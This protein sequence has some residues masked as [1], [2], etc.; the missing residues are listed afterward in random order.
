[1]SR[2]LPILDIIIVNWNAGFLL[3]ACL[4]SVARADQQGFV[5]SRIVVVDNGSTDGSLERIGGMPL[6]LVVMRN[7][8]NR[9]F[10][11]ACNQGAEGSRA[12][13]L[14]FLNPDM[15][16]EKESLSRAV[17]WMQSALG[18]AT[19]IL[20]IQLLGEEGGV[21][22]TCARFPKP[23]H[24]LSQM[25]GLY[26][27]SPRLFPNHILSRWNHR[28][29]RTVDH[30]IGAFFLI[31]HPLFEALQGFDERFFVY[32]EDLDLSLRAN[33]AGWHSYYLAEAR[34]Q[35]KGGGTSE[36]VK[37]LRIYYALQSRVLYGYRHFSRPAATAL[38]AG[39][40]TL[41]PLARMV[42]ALSLR[43]P[44]TVLET[45]RAFFLLWEG[46]PRILRR[47]K[48]A[49]KGLSPWRI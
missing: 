3:E 5:L 12:D 23:C 24:F 33:R 41:E 31:R 25:L 46:L 18:A 45:I 20:G 39:T 29:N 38:L 35:H 2:K 7:E 9:G 48:A 8:D 36:Q 4:Q 44:S 14:L 10:A 1:M 42:R 30:V 27:L 37:A 32:L 43:S 49:R 19:G 17:A 22:R 11:A 34:A 13:Y 26:R 15:V 21:S 6:P 47:E 28:E 40:L 16:L